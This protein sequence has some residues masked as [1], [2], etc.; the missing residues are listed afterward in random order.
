[1]YIKMDTMKL[2]LNNSKL[3]DVDKVLKLF[4]KLQI[5]NILDYSTLKVLNILRMIFNLS[6]IKLFYMLPMEKILILQAALDNFNLLGSQV[7][8][9]SVKFHYININKLMNNLQS[10]LLKLIKLVLH[11]KSMVFSLK[12]KLL[13]LSNMITL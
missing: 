4:R 9:D 7:R 12:P 10:K 5:I 13:N 1:M 3:V 11:L 8:V 6:K 2:N